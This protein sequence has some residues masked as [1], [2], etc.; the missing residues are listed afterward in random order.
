MLVKYASASENRFEEKKLKGKHKKLI[1]CICC[2]F[3]FQK[4]CAANLVFRERETWRLKVEASNVMLY[5][6]ISQID[7]SLSNFINI[8]Y[9]DRNRHEILTWYK[10][11]TWSDAPFPSK[12]T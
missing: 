2:G 9:K 1:P 3:V 7:E 10:I 6:Y 11:S 8:Y 12:E 5:P 4:F